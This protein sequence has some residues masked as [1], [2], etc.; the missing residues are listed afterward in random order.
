MP[1]VCLPAIKACRARIVRLDACGVPVVGAK[2]VASFKGF[3]SVGRSPEYEEG[4]EFIQKNA[5]GELCINEKD[6]SRLKRINMDIQFCTIDPDVVEMT[7]GNRLL[8]DGTGNAL[9]WATGENTN[10][11]GFSLEIW[12]KVAGGVCDLSG[13]PQWH[14]WAWPFITNGTL[15]DMT[16]ENGPFV[17]N[18]TGFTKKIAA[19]DQ[20]GGGNTGPF[21]VLPA[22]AALLVGEHEAK[23]ITS[24]QPPADACG[25]TALAA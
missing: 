23:Y 4:E 13:N 21:D 11:A 6:Q 25:A 16:F 18:V 3:V 10:E 14:Y 7:T 2:S 15:G 24:T 5:C 17:F 19:A 12:Q 8:V 1:T 9:G 22:S 20:W